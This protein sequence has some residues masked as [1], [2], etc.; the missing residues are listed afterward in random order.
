MEWNAHYAKERER[1]SESSFLRL[2]HP[3]PPFV[4]LVCVSIS[5][6]GLIC[7]NSLRVLL[8]EQSSLLYLLHFCIVHI[9]VKDGRCTS[10]HVPSIHFTN[11]EVVSWSYFSHSTHDLPAIIFFCCRVSSFL[12]KK[13]LLYQLAMTVERL[14]CQGAAQLNISLPSPNPLNSFFFVV[15]SSSSCF[16][17]MLMLA[18]ILALPS[19]QSTPASLSLSLSLLLL[20]LLP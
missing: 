19:T 20:L 5:L 15:S 16:S 6:S 12:T 13:E 8:L 10:C 2:F 18:N 4:F 14:N 7:S 17:F 11:E 3:P 9:F 1:E